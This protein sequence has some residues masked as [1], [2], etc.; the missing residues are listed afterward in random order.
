MTYLLNG[1]YRDDKV[2]F[3][4]C[5][6]VLGRAGGGV[7]E[8]VYC[9]NNQTENS[10]LILPCKAIIFQFLGQLYPRTCRSFQHM[11]ERHYSQQILMLGAH[12]P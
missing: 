3:S 10:L 2:R 7:L 5:S 6:V 4:S 11:Q 9:I 12:I 8:K 1:I